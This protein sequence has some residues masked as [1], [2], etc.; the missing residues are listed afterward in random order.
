M[1]TMVY[2]AGMSKGTEEPNRTN[3][4]KHLADLRKKASLSQAQLAKAVG[5]PQRT[6][7]NYETIANYIPSSSL[8]SL[9]DALGVSIEELIGMP[10]SKAPRR[11]PKSR[12]EKQLD[13][14]RR[15][16]KQDQDLAAQLLDRLLAS[17]H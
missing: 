5:L 1:E 9:A 7:A 2:I 3:L 8:P 11:G 17:A 15:L 16:P 14:L 13:E 12:L 4:G 6:I 10:S